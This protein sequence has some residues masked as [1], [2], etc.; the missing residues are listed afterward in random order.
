MKTLTS[1]NYG[2]DEFEVEDEYYIGGIL[3]GVC[4]VVVNPCTVDTHEHEDWTS[5]QENVL[6]VA[7]TV[8]WEL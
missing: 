8:N 3:A 5:G 2:A 1:I 7:N 4:G 6:P